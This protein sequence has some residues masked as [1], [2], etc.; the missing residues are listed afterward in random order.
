MADEDEVGFEYDQ[1]EEGGDDAFYDVDEKEAAEVKPELQKLYSQH[2]ECILDYVEE[3]V[4]KLQQQ[5]IVPGGDKVDVQHRTYPFLTNFE[6][7]KIIGLRA[8][9]ISRGSVPF[10]HV[11]KHITDVRDI[12]RLELEQK[13]LPYIIKRPLPNGTY[14]YWRLSDL[15][16]L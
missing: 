10:V 3:I 6:R 11:P 4:P 15:L 9:Q 12:A 7:T 13:R 16:I 8:N 1:G 14:E 2:P 5:F